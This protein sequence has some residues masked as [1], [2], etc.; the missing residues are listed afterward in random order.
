MSIMGPYN[1]VCVL[2][3]FLWVCIG[4]YI[5]FCVLMDSNWVLVSPYRFIFGFIYSNGSL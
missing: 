5:S 2:R 1:S 3:G 4:P